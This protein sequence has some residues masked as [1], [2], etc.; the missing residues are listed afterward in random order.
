[1]EI[2]DLAMSTKRVISHIG[3]GGERNTLY[4]GVE[5]FPQ[6]T[7]FKALRGSPKRAIYA[8]GGLGLLQ[9]VLEL[10]TGLCAS[11]EAVSRKGVDTRRC[12]SK[13]AGP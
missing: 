5:A 12:A 13:D 9:M 8:S 3:W 10:D 1:M 4:K 6:E 11:E 7:R 2:L